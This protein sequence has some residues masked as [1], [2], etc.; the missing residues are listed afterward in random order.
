MFQCSYPCACALFALYVLYTEL[1]TYAYFD[2]KKKM[3]DQFQINW[4]S[5]AISDQ[6]RKYFI[7][8][9]PTF[10]KFLWGQR[11]ESYNWGPGRLAMPHL[12]NTVE[13]LWLFQA[14]YCNTD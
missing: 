3:L 8:I 10:S 13:M 12:K 14:L 11:L 2:E 4:H 7:M 9:L 1:T 5:W 6:S